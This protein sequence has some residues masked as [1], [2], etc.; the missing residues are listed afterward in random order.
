MGWDLLVPLIAKLNLARSFL[1]AIWNLT[2]GETRDKLLEQGQERL[3]GIAD[4]KIGAYLGDRKS[5]KKR[6]AA[7]AAL[8]DLSKALLLDVNEHLD[9]DVIE[10]EIDKAESEGASRASVA[11]VRTR[12]KNNRRHRLPRPTTALGGRTVGRKTLKKKGAKKAKKKTAKKAKKKAVKMGR[13]KKRAK[14]PG[15]YPGTA[16]KTKRKKAK[17]AGGTKKRTKKK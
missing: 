8:D 6:I 16:K 14:K 15:S 10:A 4:A 3:L 5:R 9:L 12:V 17:K 13:A 7:E 1:K 11:R 2:P